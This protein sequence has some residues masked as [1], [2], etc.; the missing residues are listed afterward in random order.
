MYYD[1]LQMRVNIDD[2]AIVI[3]FCFRLLVP[4]PQFDQAS[5]KSSDVTTWESIPISAMH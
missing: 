5:K 1:S 2:P 4:S 3:P